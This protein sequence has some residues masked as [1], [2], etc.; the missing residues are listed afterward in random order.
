MAI[1]LVD[2]ATRRRRQLRLTGALPRIAL[3]RGRRGWVCAA[4]D[5]LTAMGVR[6]EV[7]APEVAWPRPG[8]GR[9]VVANRVGALDDLALRTAVP[10]V[11]EQP[12]GPSPT[13]RLGRFRAGPFRDAAASGRPVCPVAIRYRTEEG[14]DP[15]TLLVGDGLGTAVRR[16]VA[17][18]GLVIEVHLLSALGAETGDP[19]TLAIL[20]EYAI[21]AGL[22]GMPNVR[23]PDTRRCTGSPTVGQQH[24]AVE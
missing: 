13:G 9:L 16:A 24:R 10:D 4:A 18:H 14:G 7:R 22:E 8:A 5:V 12:E 6:V 21:A 20:A 3:A 15:A 2:P 17:I 23:P 11:V 19:C 1:S